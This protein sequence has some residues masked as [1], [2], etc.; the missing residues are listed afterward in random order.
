MRLDSILGDE[1]IPKYLKRTT[2]ITPQPIR[3]GI[4][5][6]RDISLGKYQIEHIELFPEY[7]RDVAKNLYSVEQ[8]DFERVLTFRGHTPFCQYSHKKS[9]KE[10]QKEPIRFILNK[11]Q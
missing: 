2:T 9:N 1:K 7:Y 8:E 6:E 5:K 11:R 10:N 4:L 3:I